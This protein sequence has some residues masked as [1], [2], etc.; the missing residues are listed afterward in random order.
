MVKVN[1]LKEFYPEHKTTS[2]VKPTIQKKRRSQR[3]VVKVLLALLLI[4]V[5]LTVCL[6]L[7]DIRE[8]QESVS[9]K[10]VA[11]E[12][13]SAGEEISYLITY[14]NLEKASLT[15]VNLTLTYPADFYF[16]SASLVPANEGGNYWLLP[17]L[18]AGHTASLEVKGVMLGEVDETKTIQA[19]MAY[20]PA[21]FSSVFSVNTEFNQKIKSNLVDMWVDYSPEA[22]P[23]QDL[24]FKIHVLNHLTEFRL[25]EYLLKNRK[26][27][28]FWKLIRRLKRATVGKSKSLNQKR[29]RLLPSMANCRPL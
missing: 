26:L 8:S 25:C 1:N 3:R 15:E 12:E 23:A 28:Q 20:E 22:M 18:P 9:L 27:F 10:I 4:S 17:D 16:S 6:R 24:L 5:V 13:I 2:F 7:K 14:T 21:N 19:V 11:P 29:N